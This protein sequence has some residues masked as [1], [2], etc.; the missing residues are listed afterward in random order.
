MAVLVGVGIGVRISGLVR[1]FG[2]QLYVGGE[3]ILA[4]EDIWVAI[5]FRGSGYLG[6]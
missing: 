5:L 2:W 4:G 1:I 6:W 3:K